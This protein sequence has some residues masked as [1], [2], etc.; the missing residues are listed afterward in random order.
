MDAPASRVGYWA[1]LRVHAEP[2]ANPDDLLVRRPP[3]RRRGPRPGPNYLGIPGR[4]AIALGQVF[5]VAL[6]VIVQLWLVTGALSEPLSGRSG[7]LIWFALA[8]LLGFILVL[9][10]ALRPLRRIEEK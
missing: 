9:V 6:I 3:Q 1:A 7:L 4:A 5:F 2:R 8:S 10:I